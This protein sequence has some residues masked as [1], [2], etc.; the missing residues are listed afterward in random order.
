MCGY[1]KNLIHLQ[2]VLLFK[3]SY[4]DAA[5]PNRCCSQRDLDAA[6]KGGSA[7]LGETNGRARTSASSVEPLAEPET[8][9]DQRLICRAPGSEFAVDRF[10]SSVA[11]EFRERFGS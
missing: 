8:G 2:P 6:T 9:F 5:S 1:I 10:P 4:S 7:E 11:W 3:D